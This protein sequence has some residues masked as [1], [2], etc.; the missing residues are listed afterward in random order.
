LQKKTARGNTA[1]RL[2]SEVW[3]INGFV[4][5]YLKNIHKKASLQF[6]S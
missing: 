4:A 2:E 6:A 1:R 3:L 5:E